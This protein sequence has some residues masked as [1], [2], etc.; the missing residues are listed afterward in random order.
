MKTHISCFLF[1]LLAPLCGVRSQNVDST[2]VI[3]HTDS[4]KKGVGYWS[5]DGIH[6]GLSGSGVKWCYD[7]GAA[8]VGKP[9]SG[10]EFVPMIWDKSRVTTAALAMAKKSGRTLLAFNEPD[11][12]NQANMTVA[13][14][15]ALWPQLQATGMRLGSPAPTASGVLPG[16]WLDAFVQ[17]IR[18]QG[19]RLDFICVHYYSGRYD[20]PRAATVELKGYLTQVYNQYHMPIWLTEFSLTNWKTPATSEEQRSFIKEVVPM[21]ESL[22]F[23]ERYAW[24]AFPRFTGDK[25]A[26][27]NSHLIN[28]AYQLNPSGVAYRDAK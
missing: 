18:A 9:F 8:P 11:A 27:A 14:A 24:F 2:A 21:L 19:L 1:L 4:V 12:S 13:E 7:W 22:P 6:H 26:L 28:D 3:S 25:N 5:S 23:L 17:G 15:L 10:I 20:D 16:K